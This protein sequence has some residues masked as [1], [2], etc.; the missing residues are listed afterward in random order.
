MSEKKTDW[1]PICDLD[2]Y[3]WEDNEG[4]L[5]GER[6]TAVKENGEIKLTCKKCGTTWKYPRKRALFVPREKQTGIV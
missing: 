3:F 6:C 4:K 2:V 5:H 1:C